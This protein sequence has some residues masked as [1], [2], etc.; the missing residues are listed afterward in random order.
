MRAII[1]REGVKVA[2]PCP[3]TLYSGWVS[4]TLEEVLEAYDA[5]H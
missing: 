2:A 1:K 5:L 4:L 3:S